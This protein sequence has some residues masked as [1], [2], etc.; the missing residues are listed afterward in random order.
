MK[1]EIHTQLFKLTFE[2]LEYKKLVD[3]SLGEF[4]ATNDE[5][6]AFLFHTQLGQK[7]REKITGHTFDLFLEAHKPYERKRIIFNCNHSDEASRLLK[8]LT[9]QKFEKYLRDEF[10]LT[11]NISRNIK[12]LIFD[13]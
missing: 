4:S 13:F 5:L 2:Y 11:M 10:S 9:N 8:L 6:D 3:I 7:L 1:K 12:H